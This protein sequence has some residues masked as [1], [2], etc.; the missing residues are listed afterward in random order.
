MTHDLEEPVIDLLCD[1]IQR[2][3]ITPE[4]AGCQALMSERLE[5][6]GFT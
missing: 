3:S 1:L 5:R 4:D 6:L 2:R